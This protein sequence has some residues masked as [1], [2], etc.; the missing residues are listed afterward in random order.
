MNETKLYL[1]EREMTKLNDVAKAMGVSVE[2]I[3]KAA[4]KKFLQKNLSAKAK[5]GRGAACGK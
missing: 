2:D 1:T 5:H 3:V 4:L